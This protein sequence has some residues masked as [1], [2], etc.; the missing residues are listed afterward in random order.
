[1]GGPKGVCAISQLLSSQRYKPVRGLL[2]NGS[3]W[4]IKLP[5]RHTQ[6][7]TVPVPSQSP[8]HQIRS[9]SLVSFTVQSLA[10]TRDPAALKVDRR[11]LLA[12]QLNVETFSLQGFRKLQAPL[13]C[14]SVGTSMSLRLQ[15]LEVWVVAKSG[16]APNTVTSRNPKLRRG[17]ALWCTL[18]IGILAVNV[19]ANWL[20]CTMVVA[21]APIEPK[22]VA[23][24]ESNAKWSPTPSRGGTM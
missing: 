3:V 13:R 8:M 17:I 6:S 15:R 19:S 22:T 1:M 11:A 10:G 20:Q 9:L 24:R 18:T 2:G 23:D 4:W 12:Q 7:A 5:W 14:L 16:S 21:R